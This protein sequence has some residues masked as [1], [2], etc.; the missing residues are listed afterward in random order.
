[1]GILRDRN[2]K[3]YG[4]TFSDKLPPHNQESEEAV[5]GSLL[6][7]GEIIKGLSLFP[8]DFYHETNLIIYKAM[9]KLKEDGVGINQITVAQKLQEQDKLQEVGGAAYLSYLISKVPTSLDCDYYADIVKRLSTFRQLIT[10]GGR[11]ASLGFDGSSSTTEALSK[12]D[13]LLLKLRQ[14]AGG[15]YIIT[16]EERTQRLWDRYE[17]LYTT[18]RGIAVHTGLKDLDSKLGGGFFPGDLIILA[19]R[20][21][22]GKTT[23]LEC[24]SNFIARSQNVLFCSAEMNIEG[25]SD[26]DVAGQIG[27]PISQVRFGGYDEG[28]Y[29]DIVD[30]AIPYINELKVY[31]LD[32]TR[33]SQLTTA[34]IYQA[35]FDMKSRLGLELVVVDYLGL[36]NDKYGNNN[37]DRLGYITRNLK[38]IAMSLHVP[39]LGAHQLSRA[40]ESREEK[41]PQLHDLRDSGNIEQDADVVLFLY[42]ESYYNESQSNI[43]EILI[44]KQRQGDSFWGVKVYYDNTH[45][46]AEVLR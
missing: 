45:H 12:A 24:I 41:R 25:L 38:Q 33:T 10:V 42:R 21:S 19:A 2:E 44:R 26:R 5:I 3:R 14:Q 40:V 1:M 4:M 23:M 29:Q 9:L 7:D 39:V 20:P 6:I 36:L 22:M 34:N 32:S 13:S 43:T 30:K 11:I 8:N 27:V 28:T 35:A 31:H 18:E 46:T 37:N 16:P 15:S 17:K